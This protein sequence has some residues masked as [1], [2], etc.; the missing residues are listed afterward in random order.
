MSEDITGSK[1]RLRLPFSKLILLVT[2]YVF[3]RY[4]QILLLLPCSFRNTS[5]QNTLL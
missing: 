5:D 1:Q 2:S 3:W 4:T